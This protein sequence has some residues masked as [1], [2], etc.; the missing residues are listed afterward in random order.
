MLEEGVDR[1]RSG[2]EVRNTRDRGPE[3]DS[4]HEEG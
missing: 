4:A 3:M 2:V 1:S